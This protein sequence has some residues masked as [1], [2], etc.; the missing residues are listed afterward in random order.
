[1]SQ[2]IILKNKEDDF[3]LSLINNNSNKIIDYLE[4]DDLNWKYINVAI[5]K[6]KI[7][8]LFSHILSSYISKIKQDHIKKYIKKSLIEYDI[9]K[10][11]YLNELNSIKQKFLDENIDFIL[12]K[13]LAITY[14]GYRDFGDLDILIKEKD[15]LSASEILNELNYYYIKISPK[16]S[17]SKKELNDITKQLHW[18]NEF[19]FYNKDNMLLIELHT[20]LFQKKYIYVEN[21]L[22]LL[23]KIDM[24]WN[25]KIFDKDLQC[26]KLSNE[27]LLILLCLHAAIK[28]ALY[29]DNFALR[30]LIDIKQV[31]S[32]KIDWD[33][34]KEAV[35]SLKITP[36]VYFSLQL[37]EQFLSINDA[38][39]IILFLKNKLGKKEQFIINIHNKCFYSLIKGSIIY[40]KLYKFLLPFV[41]GKGILNIIKTLLFIDYLFPTKLRM[42][43]IY[44]IKKNSPFIYLTYLINPFRW[45][46]LLLRR[47]VFKI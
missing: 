19:G 42:E 15:L 40:T 28:R 33:Y 24:F 31:I 20:N 6:N 39:D 13:G 16:N 23:N 14:K 7:R 45:I 47:I 4:K 8:I 32:K 18:N 10:K 9:N 44:K 12:L 43:Q 5:T 36:Y 29:T 38:N 25:N 21:I 34:F 27:D 41:L 2:N 17:L 37:T 30:G 1:M 26:F 46:Y 22:F 11:I 3:I 35:I